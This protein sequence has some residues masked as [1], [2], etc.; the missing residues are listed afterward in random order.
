MGDR[1]PS[2]RSRLLFV[3]ATVAFLLTA[4]TISSIYHLG[5]GSI[6]AVTAL[7]LAADVVWIA[8]TGDRVVLGW[9]LFGTVAGFAELAADGWLVATGTLIYPEGEPRLFASPAYMP[10]AWAMVLVQFGALATWL[11]DRFR[12]L[13]AALLTALG[14]GVNIPI[15]E[16]L[17]KGA[18]W[19]YYIDTPLVFAAPYYV[20]VA[21]FLLAVPLV[22]FSSGVVRGG[23]SRAS[24]LGVAEGV[25]MLLASI[26]A[27]RLVGPC[28]GAWIQLPCR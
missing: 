18:G 3:L 22:V 7:V 16:H 24:L 27:F 19:W 8:R 25:V 11:R 26:L 4:N 10:F 17:A 28:S 5:P 13:P 23:L 20:I 2:D 6:V 14:A 1:P 21:E 9:L 12:P 15:Y